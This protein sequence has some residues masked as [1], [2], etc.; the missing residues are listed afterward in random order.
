MKYFPS[1][2]SPPETLAM[3]ERIEAHQRE[4]GYGLYAL[5]RKDNGQFI[6][7]TGLWHPTF[8]SFF[9]PCVEIG[10]R[11][12]KANWGQG[13]AQEAARACLQYGFDELGLK[14]IYS[15]TSVHNLSSINVMQK[16]GMKYVDEFEHPK[17]AEG[18]WLRR[19]VLYSVGNSSGS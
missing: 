17:V 5:E 14:E 19:H 11:L 7:Y 8:D 16:I 6:G 4:H 2:L 1:N 9:T 10:W 3:M 18:N 15:F 13:F 12:S